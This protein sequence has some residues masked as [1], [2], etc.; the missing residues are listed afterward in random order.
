MHLQ[1]S[2]RAGTSDVDD[3]RRAVQDPPVRRHPAHREARDDTGAVEGRH[4]MRRGARRQVARAQLS[5][6]SEPLRSETSTVRS[7][8]DVTQQRLS[9]RLQLRTQV[10]LKLRFLIQVLRD[11]LERYTCLLTLLGVLAQRTAAMCEQV[12]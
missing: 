6:I 2:Q 12:K 8:G 5:F 7:S 4:G 9:Q 10:R 3:A 1:A 11:G